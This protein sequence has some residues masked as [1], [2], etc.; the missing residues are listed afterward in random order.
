MTGRVKGL[1]QIKTK[2]LILKVCNLNDNDRI[3][4]ILTEDYGKMTVMAKGVR[5]QKHKFFSAMQLFCYTDFV[6]EKKLGMYYPVDARIIENFFNLRSSVQKVALATYISDIV[7]AMP[8]EFSVEKEY[9]SFILNTLFL[10]A[11]IDYEKDDALTKILKL[12]TIFEFK[13]LCENGYAPYVEKCGVC[14][15]EKNIKYFDLT[16]G[17]VTCKDCGENNVNSRLVPI[18]E[19][20]QKNLYYI[21]SLD[22]RRVFSINLSDRDVKILSDI[23]EEYMK[24]QMEIFLPS[25]DYFKNII[26]EDKIDNNMYIK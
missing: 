26:K 5:S 13:T 3:F 24:W 10:I 9:F 7:N 19:N 4:T 1:A 6:L 20:I 18:D 25:L 15:C 16:K 17:I 8:D 11:K 21:A 2:A 14:N 22:L 12:K 23:S